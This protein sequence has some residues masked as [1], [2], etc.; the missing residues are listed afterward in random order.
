MTSN[1]AP[2]VQEVDLLGGF[3]DDAPAAPAE[4]PQLPKVSLDDDFDDFQSAP[5]PVSAP[6]SA[7]VSFAPAAA[8]AKPVPNVF[9]LLGQTKPASISTTPAT[10]PQY[11]SVTPG[12]SA[13]PMQLTVARPNYGHSS[14]GS[15][16]VLSPSTSSSTP[17]A[18]T[19]TTVAPKSSGN[20]DDLWNLSIGG[21]ASASKPSTS[22]AVIAGKSI[23]DLEREKATA[24]MWGSTVSIGGSRP[25]AA[26]PVNAF[27]TATATNGG[28]FGN[29]GGDDLL[30]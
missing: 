19:T 20:F 6:V 4:N 25:A 1:T 26:G 11:S 28:G 21:S 23:K 16:S 17:A 8:P 2:A 13:A 22:G 29:V 5:P 10:L 15:F 24:G 30:L 12:F 7:P 14:S 9:D 18:A 27:G 3:G